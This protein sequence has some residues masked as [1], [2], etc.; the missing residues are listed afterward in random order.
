MLKKKLSPSVWAE[1]VINFRHVISA[2]VKGYLDLRLTPYLKDPI[3]AWDFEGTRREVVVCAPEQTGKTLCWLVGLLWTFIFKH[4]LSLVCYE[5]DEKAEEI[6]TEKFKPLMEAIPELAAELSMPKSVRG[7]RYKF[8]SLI[9]YFQGSGKRIT[10]KSA[11]INV[12]DELDDWIEHAAQVSNLSDMRKRSRSF[13]ESMLYMVCTVKGSEANTVAGT[14]KSKIW[15]EFKQSSMGFWHLRCQNMTCSSRNHEHPNL[16]MRSADI[17][18]MQFETDKA[19]NL[20]LGTCRLVCPVC[21]YEHHEKEKRKMNLQGGYIHK[22]PERLIGKNPKYGFQW[23]LLASVWE[24]CCWDNVAM[25]QLKAGHSGN[26]KD[27]I[28]FDNSWRGL[29]FRMRKV[30][31]KAEVAIRGRAA[32]VPPD[33]DTIEAV[34]L[35]A[36]TQDY[37]WKWEVRALDKESCRWQLAY[38][39]AEYL[40]LS[41]DERQT[42]NERRELEAA[43]KNIEFVPVQ[44]LEEVFEAEYL[45]INPLLGMID[46]GG[47]R[48]REVAAFVADHEQF[49]AYKGDNRGADKIRWSENQDKLLLCKEKEFKSDLLYYILVHDNPDHYCWRLLPKEQL[50]DEYVR[51]IAA[52][53]PDPTNKSEGHLFENYT[54]MNR[55]H[56]YF[57]TGKMYLALE[58]MAIQYLEPTCWRLGKAEVLNLTAQDKKAT[59]KETK[60]QTQSGSWMTGYKG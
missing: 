6:N 26:L 21:K 5:S 56:D 12:T 16:T 50:T 58:E 7:D 10:S 38:G 43:E 34:F 30:N 2:R 42:I 52:M 28:E 1:K 40:S 35:N 18:N 3:D 31:A 9:S 15:A 45:G 36:D 48:K 13:P 17:H 44:T 4:C 57:D 27:Q 23:G 29:P 22:Y 49:Y 24:F 14:K 39:F 25:M 53:Q 59:E 47:H 55:V 33:P 11:K 54:H 20:V 37:G 32:E 60:P 19:G 41:D 46:E 51:E 8:S